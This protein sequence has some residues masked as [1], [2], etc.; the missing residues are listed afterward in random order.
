MAIFFAAFVV[1]VPVTDGVFVV[2]VFVVDDDEEVADADDGFSV[3]S[4]FP[5]FSVEYWRG[6]CVVDT[7]AIVRNVS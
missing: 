2:A 7:A 1:A 6:K 3:P 5:L 4:E